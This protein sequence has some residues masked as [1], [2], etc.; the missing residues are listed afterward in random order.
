MGTL[1]NCLDRLARQG[2][3]QRRRLGSGRLAGKRYSVRLTVWLDDEDLRRLDSLRQRCGG[4]R[5][6]LL[7]RLVRQGLAQ[8]VVGE[9]PGHDG[10]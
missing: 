8:E 5:A 10:R 2:K 1:T 9:T 7:Q 3:I 4:K 6:V